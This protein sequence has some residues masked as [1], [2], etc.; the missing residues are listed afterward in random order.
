M[1]SRRYSG[2]GYINNI[3]PHKLAWKELHYTPAQ[4]HIH[5]NKLIYFIK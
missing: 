2:E 3:H 4:N 1:F 5:I